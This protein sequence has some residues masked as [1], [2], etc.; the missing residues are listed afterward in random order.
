ML[1]LGSGLFTRMT[2]SPLIKTFSTTPKTDLILFKLIVFTLYRF[3][4]NKLAKR[5]ILF[6]IVSSLCQS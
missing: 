6:V 4:L 1:L 2:K 3:L 5:F